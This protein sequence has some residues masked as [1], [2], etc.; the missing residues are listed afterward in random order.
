MGLLMWTVANR[1]RYDRSKLRY[2]SDLTDAEWALVEPFI[3][4]AKRGGNKRTVDI[5][6]VVNGVMYVLGTGCQWA[7]LPRD[8]PPRSTNDY[9]LRWQHDRTLE[10]LHHALYVQCRE[11]AGRDASPTVGIIDSQSVKAAEKGGA[12]TRTAMTRARR[13][14]ARSATS[15]LTRKAC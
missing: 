8:L 13:S 7:A 3:P 9:F 2:P 15:L 4:P 1:G 14:G 11:R 5:R 10:R 12:R 6:E